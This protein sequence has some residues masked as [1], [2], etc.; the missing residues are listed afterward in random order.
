M[1]LSQLTMG[2]DF[3]YVDPL[4]DLLH[5]NPMTMVT[6]VAI[7]Y[8]GRLEFLGWAWGQLLTLLS[9]SCRK[10]GRKKKGLTFR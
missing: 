8:V 6:V 1:M 7:P 2:A 9:C 4:W 5:G 3:D 10:R